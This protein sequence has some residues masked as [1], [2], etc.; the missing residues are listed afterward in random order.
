MQ[1]IAKALNVGVGT[2]IDGSSRR[3]LSPTFR[4]L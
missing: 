1:A 4:V 2:V 3:A